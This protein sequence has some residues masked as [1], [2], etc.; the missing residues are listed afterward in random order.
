MVRITKKRIG[1]RDRR[2]TSSSNIYT[3]I[4][5]LKFAHRQPGKHPKP[6]NNYTSAPSTTMPPL[7]QTR[8]PPP[9][10]SHLPHSHYYSPQPC[11]PDKPDAPSPKTSPQSYPSR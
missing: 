11:H 10:S 7:P 1:V 2:T 4:C 3:D 6:T 8:P 9:W 5:D